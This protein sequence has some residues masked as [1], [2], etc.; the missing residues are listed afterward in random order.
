MKLS[1]ALVLF[2]TQLVVS[3]SP[4]ASD[5]E[6]LSIPLTKRAQLTTD[7]IVD[8]TAVKANLAFAHAKY[9]RGFRQYRMNVGVDHPLAAGF[10]LTNLTADLTKRDVGEMPLNEQ[11]GG[12]LWQG[13]ITVGTPAQEYTIDFDTGSS[14]LFLPAAA[15]NASC[16][17][18]K[19]YD[20][21]NSSTSQSREL[22]FRLR[23]GDGSTVSGDQYNDTVGIGI[24]NAI[25]QALGAATVYS[26]FDKNQFPPDG[27][28]GMAY[29]SIAVLD[30]DPVV[31]TLIAQGKTT[32]PVFAFK[33]TSVGAELSVGSINNT[34]YTGDFTQVPVTRQAYWEVN[35]DGILIN[36][37]QVVDQRSAIID[38]GTTLVIGDP[39]GV[40]SLWDSVPGAKNASETIGLPGF[41]TFPCDPPPRIE[42]IF[43]CKAFLLSPKTYN[44]GR[45]SAGSPD[46]VGGIVA[47][48]GLSFWAVGDV[49]L[50]NVYTSFDF[51]SNSVGFADLA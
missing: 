10:A 32:D 7:G 40:Q 13:I 9:E 29:R 14:D 16:D 33:L 35:M 3:A 41:Y 8:L 46:C 42:F 19:R 23:Y 26:G 2:A 18:H 49:F 25:N 30:A 47:Q 31:Q 45:V 20:P 44:L 22:T 12:Q 34:L 4:V 38:T 39:K 5:D 37:T 51:G 17:G 36:A 27:L 1:V 11:N 21:T 6:G 43:G 50:Q 15:C 24:L 28:M 48:S